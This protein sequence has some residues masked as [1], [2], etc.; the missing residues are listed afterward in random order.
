MDSFAIALLL[1]SAAISF[2]IGRFISRWRA[3]RQQAQAH[4]QAARAKAERDAAPVTPSLN[5][6]KRK[7]EQSLRRKT[8]RT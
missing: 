7:R 2:G 5:K 1:V 6:S 4:Q 3:K 8:P